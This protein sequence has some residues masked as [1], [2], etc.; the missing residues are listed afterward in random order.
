MRS[1]VRRSTGVLGKGHAWRTRHGGLGA[2][3]G[4]C[5]LL[6]F[7]RSETDGRAVDD[8]AMEAACNGGGFKSMGTRATGRD[9]R[10]KQQRA[11]TMAGKACFLFPL[12]LCSR[13][14]AYLYRRC[15]GRARAQWLASATLI[16]CTYTRADGATL[17]ARSWRP[18]RSA[19]RSQ[20]A[21]TP[22][23]ASVGPRLML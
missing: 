13:C 2:S 22:R 20:D 11:P 4:R 18:A 10:S 1:V 14:I 8:E 9:G 15:M 21:F 19:E 7:S 3:V 17:Q 23:R 5:D 6:L 12:E 16:C